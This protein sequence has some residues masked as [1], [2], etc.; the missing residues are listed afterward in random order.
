M[1]FMTFCLNHNY[2]AAKKFENTRKFMIQYLAT[3]LR[4][5]EKLLAS[6]VFNEL[7]GYAKENQ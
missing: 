5:P 3:L 7:C 4:T 6:N 2:Q 1:N